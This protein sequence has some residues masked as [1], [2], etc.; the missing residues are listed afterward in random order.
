MLNT[1]KAK[2][3]LKNNFQ[4]GGLDKVLVDEILDNAKWSIQM[5]SAPKAK[6]AEVISKIGG[7]PNL[8]SDIEWPIYKGE[9]MAFI[10][11]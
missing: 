1:T 11:I 9:P 4:W 3:A 7:F 2:K 6:S 10:G 5:V 8:S